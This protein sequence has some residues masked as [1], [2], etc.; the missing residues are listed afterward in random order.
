MTSSAFAES[1]V[2]DAVLSWL[3]S[4]G[5]AILYGPDIAASEPR[6]KDVG[7]IAEATA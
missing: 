2:E 7:R 1:V 6:V 5:Y 4:I 3:E